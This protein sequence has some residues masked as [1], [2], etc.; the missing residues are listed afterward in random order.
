MY[1]AKVQ[2]IL[3]T[4][5]EW[6]IC[7]DISIF[8]MR[9]SATSSRSRCLNHRVLQRVQYYIFCKSESACQ[10]RRR[11]WSLGDTDTASRLP[12]KEIS[13]GG[14][15]TSG[16]CLDRGL[17]RRRGRESRDCDGILLSTFSLDVYWEYSE[18]LSM[19]LAWYNMHHNG[20][21]LPQ[22]VHW[23]Q[24]VGRYYHNEGRLAFRGQNHHYPRTHLYNVYRRYW[25]H[26]R[27]ME[28]EQHNKD[29]K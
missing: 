28:D 7:G 5:E 23:N 16:Y 2:S 6:H 11:L 9:R 1:I 10:T 19:V 27:G 26:H 13:G 22:Q 18:A 25:L 24:G 17:D 12:W 14:R 20:S 15:E 4:K 29:D 3:M 21:V 8:I